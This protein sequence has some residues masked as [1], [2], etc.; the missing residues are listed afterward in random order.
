[1]SS[2]L[3]SP[4][5]ARLLC[6]GSPFPSCC[7]GLI[8]R[9]ATSLCSPALYVPPR[10]L[11]H[12]SCASFCSVI[13]CDSCC[14]LTVVH[15]H[16]AQLSPVLLLGSSAGSSWWVPSALRCPSSIW[17]CCGSTEA[18]TQVTRGHHHPLGGA[19]PG[20]SM[21]GV[22]RARAAGGEA[23][24]GRGVSAHYCHSWLPSRMPVYSASSSKPPLTVTVTL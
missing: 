8:P 16:L 24:G 20:R 18:R 23:S 11:S 6:F 14:V 4:H 19:L 10:A 13:S 22:Q 3:H 12:S 17:Q 1:L 7:L 5:L 21:F 15:A 9:L 2:H